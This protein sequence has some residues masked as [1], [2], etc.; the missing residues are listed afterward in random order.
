MMGKFAGRCG[1]ILAVALLL[2]S[3]QGRPSSKTA[4]EAAAPGSLNGDRPGSAFLAASVGDQ[5]TYC[6]RSVKAY[7]TSAVQSFAVSPSIGNITPQSFCDQLK[8]YFNEE[9]AHR[10]ERLSQAS[11]TTI[12]LYAK[13]KTRSKDAELERME[14]RDSK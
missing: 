3:C 9:P 6:T 11:A 10:E 1:L 12:L 2:A 4:A 5:L 8:A 14:R 7:K 13:P